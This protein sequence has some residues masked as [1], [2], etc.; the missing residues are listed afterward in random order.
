MVPKTNALSIRPQGPLTDPP[1]LPPS[2]PR[3]PGEPPP[4]HSRLRAWERATGP[5]SC[6]ARACASE[7]VT[8]SRRQTDDK[9]HQPRGVLAHQTTLTAR[10]FLRAAESPRR[11]MRTHW[12]PHADLDSWAHVCSITCERHVPSDLHH[13]GTATGRGDDSP[14][15]EPGLSRQQRD[16][17]TTRRCGP[18]AC[19]GGSLLQTVARLPT[20]TRS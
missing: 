3:P 17:R 14:G 13:S 1:S 16:V 12:I 2:D 18:C 11:I 4:G 15:I 6:R 8:G 7:R 20:P 9:Q 19:L 10:V 5:T